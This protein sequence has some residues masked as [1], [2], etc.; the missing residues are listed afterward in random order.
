ARLQ[1]DFDT[2][3]EYRERVAASGHH[4]RAGQPLHPQGTRARILV[5]DGVSEREACAFELPGPFPVFDR[6]S[7]GR[8]IVADA[9]CEFCVENAVRLWAT[10][11]VEAR[12]CLGD[13]I[14]DLQ[15]DQADAVWAGYFDEGIFG[16]YGWGGS[17]EREPIGASGLV[18][19][20]ADGQ[21]IWQYE[22]VGR[23]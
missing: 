6:L 8:W 13:G 2:H 16:N 10:G 20:G 11:D 15:R 19:F 18:R 1:A 23:E 17:G 4:P 14:A 22:G 9:R 5:H 7:D 3:A 12:L 21:V